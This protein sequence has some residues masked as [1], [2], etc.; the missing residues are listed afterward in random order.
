MA[1]PSR[2]PAAG[3]RRAELLS[4][5]AARA[6]AADR[7]ETTLRDDV[8]ALRAAD[9]LAAP[10]PVAEGGG[11]WGTQ[12]GGAMACLDALRALG[13]ASLPVARVFEGHVNA[14]KLVALYADGA[15]RRAAFD[16]VRGGALLGVWGADAPDRPL[17]IAGGTRLAGAKRFASGLG[18]LSHAIVSVPGDGGPQLLLVPAGDPARADPASWTAA[19]MRATLSGLYDF[20]GLPVAPEAWI[21]E[22]GD[23]FVEPHF[24]GGIWRYCAAHLGGAEALYAAMRDAL[25]ASGRAGDPHQGA[26][27]ARAA[28]AVETA[29]LWTRRAA[30]G[31]ETGGAAPSTAALSLLAR[32]V[33]QESCRDVIRIVEEALGTAAHM[34]GPVE[35]TR[36]DLSLFICQAAPDAKRARAAAALV[37]RAVLPEDL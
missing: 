9:W 20:E 18:V 37:E 12:P 5:I 6:A 4:G 7:G 35:R 27:I 30:R 25:A 11:G 34:A 32:E 23:W 24:E 3:A 28:I 15:A 13:R 36:R 31:V 16:L 14:V 29:R 19:G 10:L 26:R 22:P 2:L 1:E 33:V 8:E 21:G 17:G